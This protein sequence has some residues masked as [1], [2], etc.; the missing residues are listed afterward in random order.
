[1]ELG[2]LPFSSKKIVMH[3]LAVQAKKVYF[4]LFA[5]K[6][7]YFL[8]TVNTLLQTTTEKTVSTGGAHHPKSTKQNRVAD[9]IYVHDETGCC[10]KARP[11]CSQL[12]NNWDTLKY[13]SSECST[14]LLMPP[15]S[16]SPRILNNF[17][18]AYVGSTGV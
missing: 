4:L 11:G 9:I 7:V 12:A 6:K 18:F 8:K 3:H 5:G 1:M 13:H 15:H 16:S 10:R 17:N 14:P 2:L